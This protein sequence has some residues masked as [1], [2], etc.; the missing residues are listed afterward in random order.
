LRR[1]LRVQERE[2]EGALFRG[3][4]RV[5]DRRQLRQRERG[6]VREEERGPVRTKDSGQ[7][8]VVLQLEEPGPERRPL[9]TPRQTPAR[10]PEWMSLQEPEQRP[11][12]A[13]ARGP[14]W[15]QEFPQPSRG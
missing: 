8:R 6:L 5:Q 3:P 9:P 13:L 15:G 10:G 11:Q 1:L 7:V 14:V 2:L 12:R 4:L